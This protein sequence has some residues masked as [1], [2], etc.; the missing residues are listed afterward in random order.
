MLFRSAI[1]G[2]GAAPLAVNS[3]HHQ[4]VTADRLAP[5]L[6]IAARADSPRGPLVEG[7]EEPGERFVLGV[8]CHP[9]RTE[10]SPEVLERVWQ[11]FVEAAA[12]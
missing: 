5:G 1:L 4:A 11:A 6:R 12:R 9:E 3:Y 10:S 7:L 2:D 8:Q